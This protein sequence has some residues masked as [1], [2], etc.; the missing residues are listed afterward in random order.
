MLA[1]IVRYS[2]KK[3]IISATEVKSDFVLFFCWRI[4]LQFVVQFEL[5]EIG[6]RGVS[7]SGVIRVATALLFAV[8]SVFFAKVF[9]LEKVHMR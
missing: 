3:F 2:R 9:C 1:S 4:L 6:S 8:K 7:A 5:W